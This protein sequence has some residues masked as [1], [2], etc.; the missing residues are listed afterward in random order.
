MVKATVNGERKVLKLEIDPEIIKKE[1]KDML[2]DLVV[3]AI[4]IALKNVD[5]KVK[6]EFKKSTE[7]VLPNIPGFDLGSMF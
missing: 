6:E 5:E 4:N 3:A 7:G 1:D 2:Q